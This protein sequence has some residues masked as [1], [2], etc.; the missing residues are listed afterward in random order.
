[1]PVINEEL[2]PILDMFGQTIRDPRAVTVLRK[3]QDAIR[4]GMLNF[5]RKEKIDDVLTFNTLFFTDL[6]PSYNRSLNKVVLNI[7]IEI[8]GVVTRDDFK[9]RKYNYLENEMLIVKAR[10]RWDY[11]KNDRFKTLRFQDSLTLC[12]P[13]N[14]D[15]NVAANA[16]NYA[17]DVAGKCKLW[18]L[19]NKVMA[20]A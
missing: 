4:Q 16:G 14:V 19:T 12:I 11:E 2:K 7:E 3:W 9:H 8:A 15:S 1:M 13:E 18:L 5:G 17:S 6:N 10:G 20:K